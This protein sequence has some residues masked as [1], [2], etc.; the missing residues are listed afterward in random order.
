[1]TTQEKSLKN[2]DESKSLLNKGIFNRNQLK[3]IAIICMVLDHVAWKWFDTVT[4]PGILMHV[5]GRITAPCMCFFIAEGYIYTHDRL[6]YGLRLLLFT[7]ISWIPF[8]YFEYGTLP[9]IINGKLAFPP[10]W[11]QTQSMIYTL[12]LCYVAICI[13]N[14]HIH[15]LMKIFLV[16]GVCVL[17]MHADWHVSA[18]L[19]SIVFWVFHEHPIKQSIF[20][21][22]VACGKVIY[23]LIQAGSNWIA[24][25]FQFGVLL[26]IPLLL[27]YNGKKGSSKLFHKWFF[28]VFYPLQLIIIALLKN[29]VIK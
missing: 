14:S 9:F 6:K 8:H 19:F 22:I 25:V 17:D 3:Y 26:F 5:L 23:Q 12:F 7:L 16:W 10:V 29:Y 1:M 15:S 24:S 11:N 18:I 21:G 4:M 28:Y 2:L 20:F 13:L 27:L